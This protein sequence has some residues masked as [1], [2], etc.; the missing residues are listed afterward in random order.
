MN[1]RKQP[2]N[3][4]AEE[5]VLGSFLIDPA[6]AANLVNGNLHPEH[7]LLTKHQMIYR[8][9]Q[10]ILDAG[11][12]LDILTLTSELQSRNV[13]EKIGGLYYLTQIIQT[14]PSSLHVRKYANLVL[15]A[16]ARR[17]VLR[18]LSDIA[19]VAFDEQ[20][21]LSEIDPIVERIQSLSNTSQET[22]ESFD[23]IA[24]GL[25]PI[26][27][28]WPQWIPKGFITLL[29]AEPGT[30]K[31][32][33]ALDIAKRIIHQESWPDDAPAGVHQRR[34]VYVDAEL[35]PQMLH[36][37]AVRWGLDE[38]KLFVM[39]PSR[40]EMLDFGDRKCRERLRRMVAQIEPSMVI[41]DSL[42]SITLRG[43]NNI[44]DIRGILG[45]LNELAVDYNVGLLLIHHLRK[46][47]NNQITTS[48]TR[49]ISIDDFRGSGHIIAMSRSVLALS[50]VQTTRVKDRNAPRKLQQIKN[51]FGPY[52]DPLGCDLMPLHPEGVFLSWSADAPEIFKEPTKVDLCKDWMQKMLTSPQS[53]SDLVRLGK[54]QEGWSRSTIYRAKRDLGT[55]IAN[56]EGHQ[57]PD[58]KWVLAAVQTF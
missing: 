31:S 11:E 34:I 41:V 33:V 43:E 24:K 14:V 50:K 10:K 30:G 1:N 19:R 27:W 47:G 20:T 26:N 55:L 17:K 57:S 35:V 8:A 45:F 5:A 21:D 25:T 53:P 42:S 56:T 49:E 37:R 6:G 36:Q 38:S 18:S 32:L 16:A 48:T 12:P 29:G 40:N 15:D 44:E 9:M 13:L 28:L 23:Q 58:N 51:N 2:A 4:A 54:D 39:S 52:P 46:R 3:T 22:F 7:F